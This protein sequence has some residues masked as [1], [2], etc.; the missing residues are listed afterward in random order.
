MRTLVI[1]LVLC[2]I[3]NSAPMERKSYR[4]W[5]LVQVV[6]VTTE[7]V[8]FLRKLENDWLLDYWEH[9]HINK[10]AAVMLSPEMYPAF[11]SE[12][13]AHG[14]TSHVAIEDLQKLAEDAMIPAQ[15]IKVSPQLDMDHSKYHKLNDVMNMIDYFAEN[16][17]SVAKRTIGHS[18]ENR[19][20]EKLEINSASGVPNKK[21]IYLEVL[22]HARE[23]ITT[24]S[25][26]YF[27]DNLLNPDAA[28]ASEAQFLLDN[29][30]WHIVPVTNPDGYLYSWGSDR[31]WRKNR[32]NTGNANCPGVDLNRN[33]DANWGGPGTSTS[34]CSSTYLGTAAESEPETKAITNDVR[35]MSTKP[36]AYIAV[37]SYSQYLLIPFGWK[38]EPDL[39]NIQDIRNTANLGSQAISSTS[40]RSFEV[41]KPWEVLYEAAGTS[42]DWACKESLVNIP[43]CITYELLPSGNQGNSGFAPSASMI[44][45]SGDDLWHSLYAMAVE[46]NDNKWQPPSN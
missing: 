26:M 22:A 8:D 33:F 5:K 10:A 31:Y 32:R 37:H 16:K 23:W 3:A 17:A 2:G 18:L 25:T 39:P 43:F 12:V 27:I 24:A 6:P 41:G 36:V 7:Q 45:P 38:S 40:G 35:G 44:V 15:N 9:V 19:P 14:M 46:L 20:I 1:V 34:P 11:V 28:K 21:I 42:Q 30:E 29:F 4:N 13:T